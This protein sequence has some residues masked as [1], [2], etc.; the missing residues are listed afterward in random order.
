[1]SLRANRE[2]LTADLEAVLAMAGDRPVVLVGHSIGGMI[3]QTFC[4]LV[5]GTLARR[6]AGLALV[7]TMPS[8]RPVASSLE[9]SLDPGQ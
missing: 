2:N 3:L 6:V 4:H 1:V 8:R 5:P 9:L 7:H